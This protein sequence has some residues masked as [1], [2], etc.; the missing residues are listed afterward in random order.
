MWAVVFQ[1]LAFLL[2]SFFKQ[3]LTGV[4]KIKFSS[5]AIGFLY[6][7]FS[8]SLYG[9]IVG[10]ANNVIGDILS[11]RVNSPVLTVAL[12]YLP[13]NIQRNLNILLQAEFAALLYLYKDKVARFVLS[14]VKFQ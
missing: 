1:F 6:F 7:S 12:S 11:V 8:L 4:F 13:H 2:V 10:Y 9:T 14:M 5:W 3:F